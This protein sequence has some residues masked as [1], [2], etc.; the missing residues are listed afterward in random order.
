MS[1]DKD[2]R[3]PVE[4]WLVICKEVEAEENRTEAEG[5]GTV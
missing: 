5:F 2:G 1:Y 4:V 3:Y